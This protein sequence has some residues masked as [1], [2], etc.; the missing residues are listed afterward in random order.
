MEEAT[1]DIRKSVRR[2]LEAYYSDSSETHERPTN[3]DVDRNR[4]DINQVTFQRNYSPLSVNNSL[5][6]PNPGRNMEN[7]SA[8]F[9]DREIERLRAQHIGNNPAAQYE[10]AG[11]PAESTS[12]ALLTEVVHSFREMQIEIKHL[13]EQM[14]DLQINQGNLNPEHA[15]LDVTYGRTINDVRNQTAHVG[16]YLRLKETR[17]MISEFDGNSQ[18]KLKEFLCACSYAIK[19]I[20]SADERT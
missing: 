4:Q 17:D 3:G 2:N 16:G 14:R 18:T 8:E 6:E 9:V 7:I 20:N 13:R 12:N 11:Q 5:F 19:N 10:D 15:P 1:Y